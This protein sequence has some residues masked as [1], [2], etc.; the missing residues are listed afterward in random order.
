MGGED[1]VVELVERARADDRGGDRRVVEHERERQLL[2]RQIGVDRD[3]RQL[4]DQR[5]LLGADRLVAV[6]EVIGLPQRPR[7]GVVDDTL[8]LAGQPATVQ[9]RP[10]DDAE[11]VTA[12]CREHVTLDSTCERRVR[13][14]LA[15]R[16][17][18]PELFGAPV[19]V[20]DLRRRERRCPDRTDL[21]RGD[22]LVE[23]GECLV[24]R[25]R[26]IGSVHLVEVDV[27]HLQPAQAV[28]AGL[29]DPPPRQPAAVRIAGHRVSH[30]RR[31]HDPVA[32]PDQRLAEDRLGCTVVVHVG[33][34]EQRDARIDRPV[35]HAMAL[36]DVG[37]APA[38]EHHRAER[39]RRDL[40]A[41]VPE[42]TCRQVH[43]SPACCWNTRLSQ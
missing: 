32:S 10:D 43:T 5:V 6:V 23:G 41:A 8:V 2:Q 35:D 7:R 1:Q 15:R 42:A 22:E 40:H 16:S 28:V 17:R 37:V 25:R 26:R 24:D 18:H 21:A 34:V 14:L 13:R 3:G 19:H 33:R 12:T 36:V 39:D 29:L 27:I 31:Q 11:I 9:R 4:I 20:V 30:L 38:P